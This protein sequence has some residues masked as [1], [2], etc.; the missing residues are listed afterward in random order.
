[1]NSA[2]NHNLFLTLISVMTVLSFFISWLYRAHYVT[3][4]SNNYNTRAGKNLIWNFR[5]VEERLEAHR[6]LTC[7]SSA[8]QTGTT[9]TQIRKPQLCHDSCSVTGAVWLMETQ[10]IDILNAYPVTIIAFKNLSLETWSTSLSDC[11]KV[12]NGQENGHPITENGHAFF[13]T[14]LVT[15]HQAI[16]SL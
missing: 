1:M 15:I 6:L 4:K 12:P 14:D 11:E 10:K 5:S 16:L 13:S 8:V 3:Q 7:N 2:L 9:M